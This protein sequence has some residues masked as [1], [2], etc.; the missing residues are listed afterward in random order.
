MKKFS[1]IIFSFI[2]LFPMSIYANAG[3][4]LIWAGLGHLFLGN[5]LIGEFETFLLRKEEKKYSIFI[6]GIII[7]L[8]NFTSMILGFL[9]AGFLNNSIGIDKFDSNLND[10]ILQNLIIYLFL[11]ISSYLVE[12]LGLEK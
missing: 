5:I 7:I 6:T 9:I 8:A 10:Y 4:P 3:T 12:L 2:I 1:F 11:T